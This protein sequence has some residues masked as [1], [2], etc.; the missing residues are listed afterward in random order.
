P[1]WGYPFDWQNSKHAVWPKNTPYITCTPYCYEAF[2]ALHA[3]TGEQRYHD[4]AAGIA[5]FVHGDL[6]E[7]PT[8]PT[9]AAGSYSPHDSSK[10]VNASAYRAWVLIDAGQ[11]FGRDDYSSS[12]LRNLNFV[13]ESQKADGSWLYAEGVGASFIDHFHT[14]FNLKNLFKANR[15]LQRADVA[16]AIAKGFQ[17][18]HDHLFH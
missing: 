12:G 16:E 3:A 15:V 5:A 14:C 1:C 13:L 18:Y 8:S 10:V 2:L 17:Y 7:T 9:A 11:R 6:K 4:I